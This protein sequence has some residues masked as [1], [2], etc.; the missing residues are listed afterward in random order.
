MRVSF[1]Y[2]ITSALLITFFPY[3]LTFSFHPNKSFHI[4]SK[5]YFYFCLD[6]APF[7]IF[8]LDSM[9]VIDKPYSNCSLC[10]FSV[11]NDHPNSTSN[12][13]LITF[14]NNHITNENFFVRS[15]RTTNS[16]CKVVILCDENAFDNLP[17]NRFEEA[18][19]C[20]VQ[21]I[22]VPNKP[23]P[24]GSVSGVYISCMLI[25]Y[26]YILAFLLRNRGK[27]RRIIYQDLFDTFF[28]GDP[29]A[30]ILFKN[31]YEIHTTTECSSYAQNWFMRYATH[32]QNLTIPNEYMNK[33]FKNSSHFGGDAETIYEFFMLFVS[34][35]SFSS[36]WDDQIHMNYLEMSNIL[37]K[38]GLSYSSDEIE[39]FVNLK[40]PRKT[41]QH[42]G[43]IHAFSSST[44]YALA[45]HQIY[46]RNDLFVDMVKACPILDKDEDIVHKYFGKCDNKCIN[47]VMKII[48]KTNGKL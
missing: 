20:G 3:F 13:L 4:I 27:F 21:F 34:T 42:L 37:N 41:Y 39:R 32:K 18:Q 44:D 43:N 45:V 28:Q 48:N 15:L 12:D 17:Q 19:N 16:S 8:L 31:K 5:I 29:F 33:Y 11:R 36:G 6:P 22:V 23:C 25:G 7:D 38:R 2:I 35:M 14:A 26:Y 40:S 24:K 47:S 1:L 10:N 9:A 30:E 46:M